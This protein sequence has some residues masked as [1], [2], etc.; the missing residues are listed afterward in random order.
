MS[1]LPQYVLWASMP[2][3]LA[4]LVPRLMTG[5]TALRPRLGRPEPELP[6]VGRPIEQIAADLRR[7]GRKL[8]IY[9]ID[10]YRPSAVKQLTVMQVY[11]E[12][13]AEACGAL[14]IDHR[15]GATLGPARRAERQRVRIALLNAGL[16]LSA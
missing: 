1:S 4:W 10:A 9:S 15:L 11:D 6:P 2:A 12:R 5:A 8:E 3:A 16:V 7:L 13:L 14:E